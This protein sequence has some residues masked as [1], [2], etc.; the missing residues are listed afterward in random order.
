MMKGCWN[1]GMWMSSWQSSG[2]DSE[3]PHRHAK[4]KQKSGS[5]LQGTSLLTEY[6]EFQGLVGKLRGWLEKIAGLPF[7]RWAELGVISEF[8]ASRVPDKLQ[9]WYQLATAVE[10]ELMKYKWHTRLSTSKE[11]GEVLAGTEN[12]GSPFLD[13]PKGDPMA[14]SGYLLLMQSGGP[15][16]CYLPSAAADCGH[17]PAKS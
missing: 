4:L 13:D 9:A 2:T 6:I 12:L 15:L 14:S 11:P 5:S 7:L 10:L 17:E 8:S 16:D 3:T 1:W